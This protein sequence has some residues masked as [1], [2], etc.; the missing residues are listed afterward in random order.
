MGEPEKDKPTTSL[1]ADE[2]VKMGIV[3]DVE[4]QLKEVNALENLHDN[5]LKIHGKHPEPGLFP[6]RKWTGFFLL[7]ESHHIYMTFWFVNEFRTKNNI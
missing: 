4:T 2:E 5:Y 3:G 6:T 7:H 1:K